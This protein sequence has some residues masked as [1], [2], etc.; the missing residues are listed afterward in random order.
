MRTH[1]LLLLV[2]SAH[3]AGSEIPRSASARIPRACVAFPHHAFL[4]QSRRGAERG[5]E[6]TLNDSTKD[7]KVLQRKIIFTRAD[8]AP[9]RTAQLTV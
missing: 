8:R 5:G 3:H 7:T 1:P 9:K 2:R 6:A 4:V